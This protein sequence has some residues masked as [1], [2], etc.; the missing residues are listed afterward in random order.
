MPQNNLYNLLF[1]SKNF[2]IVCENILFSSYVLI[3]YSLSIPFLLIYHKNTLYCGLKLM[4]FE[5][6]NN[7]G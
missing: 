2:V 3:V 5:R 6:E 7:D 4:E 1:L